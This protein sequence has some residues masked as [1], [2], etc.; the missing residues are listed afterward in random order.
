MPKRTPEE[1]EQSL[2]EQEKTRGMLDPKKSTRHEIALLS[3]PGCIGL[4]VGVDTGQLSERFIKLDHFSSF[5]SVDKWDDPA[6]SQRQYWAVTE[7]LMK[8][9]ESRVW[10]M[11]AQKFAELVPDDMF[12]FIYIDCYAHTGQ[13]DGEVLDVLWP[14]LKPGGIFA[15]DDYDAKAFKLTVAAVDRF[16]AS[17]SLG[18]TVENGFIGENTI[19]MDGHPTWWIRKPEAGEKR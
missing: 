1:S 3:M 4:E 12:G 6:H 7:K 19:S 18:I 5:H 15:G 16:A 10:R 2:C 13:N 9:P 8:Y 14:K 11:T 17:V